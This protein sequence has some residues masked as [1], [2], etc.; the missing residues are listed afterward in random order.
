VL[1]LLQ[2]APNAPEPPLVL[3]RAGDVSDEVR[4]LLKTLHDALDSVPYPFTAG[5]RSSRPATVAAFVGSIATFVDPASVYRRGADLLAQLQR[6]EE[7]VLGL[8]IA[9]AEQVEA[10][11]GLPPLA[12]TT[13]P[14][15]KPSTE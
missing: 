15:E 8:L 11:F 3:R 12:E 5:A 9:T 13:T 2:R 14:P 10:A 6:L 7:R 4:K 1:G